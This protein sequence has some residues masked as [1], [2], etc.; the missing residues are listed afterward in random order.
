M[1]CQFRSMFGLSAASAQRFQGRIRSEMETVQGTQNP[2]W[3]P[4]PAMLLGQPFGY[5]GMG[6]YL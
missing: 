2:K 3:G 6:Q 1:S 5:L 4:M